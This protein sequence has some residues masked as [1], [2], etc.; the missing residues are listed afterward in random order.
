MQAFARPRGI[1]LQSTDVN[2][3]I[4]GTLDVLGTSHGRNVRIEKELGGVAPVQGDPYTLQEVLFNLCTNALNAMPNGGTLTLRSY[5]LGGRTKTGSARWP[6]TSAT[7]ASAFRQSTWS[8]F[9]AVFHHP[10][11]LRRHRPRTGPLPHVDLRNGR[12]DRSPQRPRPGHDLH[13][14]AESGRWGEDFGQ[15]RVSE[16]GG[17]WLSDLHQGVFTLY[18]K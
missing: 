5:A 18:L 15:V 14:R 4:E 9:R 17:E 12:P 8:G 6:S 10:R 11:R 16:I 2:Q 3:A 1:T 13:R 7:P